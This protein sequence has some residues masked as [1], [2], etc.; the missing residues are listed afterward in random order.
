MFAYKLEELR[1]AELIEQAGTYRLAR[2]LRQA[3]R[4]ERSAA[5]DTRKGGGGVNT[6]H[7]RFVRAA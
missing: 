4:A 5:K 6:R 7:E 2:Q 3:R 1:R